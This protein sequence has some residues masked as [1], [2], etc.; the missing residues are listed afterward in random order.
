MKSETDLCLVLLSEHIFNKS[1]NRFNDVSFGVASSCRTALVCSY[2]HS[3]SCNQL[4]AFQKRIEEFLR[5]IAFICK[6]NTAQTFSQY[7]EYRWIFCR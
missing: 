5:D 2:V 6:R 3:Q 1:F 4:D 7:I